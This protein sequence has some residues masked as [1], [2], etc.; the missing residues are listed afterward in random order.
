MQYIV[1]VLPDLNTMMMMMMKMMMM[2]MKMMMMMMMMMKMMMMKMMMMMMMM[3]EVKPSKG[4]LDPF[5]KAVAQLVLNR[6]IAA[7]VKKPK[8]IHM[9]VLWSGSIQCSAKNAVVDAFCSP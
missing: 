3:T 7:R 5:P 4:D 8:H 6:L 2:M 9:Q 1:P